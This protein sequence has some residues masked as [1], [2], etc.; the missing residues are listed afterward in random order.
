MSGKADCLAQVATKQ[1]TIP[2]SR[3]CHL[4][5][6][7]R[8]LLDPGRAST[9]LPNQRWRRTTSSSISCELHLIVSLFLQA[10]VPPSVLGKLSPQVRPPPITLQEQW[11]SW[12]THVCAYT[13]TVLPLYCCVISCDCVKGFNPLK[14]HRRQCSISFCSLRAPFDMY[15]SREVDWIRMDTDSDSTIFTI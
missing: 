14:C 9:S 1:R 11:L 6:R 2:A 4:A 3:S 15:F 12:E 7:W 10:T 13:I 5:W 8:I